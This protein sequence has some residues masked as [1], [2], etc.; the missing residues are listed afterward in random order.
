[1]IEACDQSVIDRSPDSA[2]Q[3]CAIEQLV[4]KIRG[5]HTWSPASTWVYVR[6]LAVRLTAC[7]TPDSVEMGGC[8]AGR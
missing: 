8:R 3:S 4:L 7:A 6:G 2:S 1:M 5:D